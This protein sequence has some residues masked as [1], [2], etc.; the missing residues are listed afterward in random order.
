[1]LNFAI[2]D[3]N[4]N[5]LDRLEKML[6]NIFTK[7]NFDA[8]VSFKANN[9]K[10]MLN[11]VSNNKIDVIMLDIN[12][13]SNKSGLELAEAIR[14]INKNS[15]IIFTTG[16]LEY[17]MIAYKFKT[18]DYLA[19]PITY[20]RLEETIK[21]L[22]DDVN[23]SPKKY[24]KIDNKN[25]IIN[26]AE[27]QYIKRDGMKLVFHT[28]TRDYDTYSSFNK[29]QDRLP[30]T[31]KRCHKSC[32]ANISQIKDVEPVSGII[33]FKD[34]STCD[35]GPK[36]KAD[37]MEVLKLMEILNNL[38]LAVSTPNELLIN[39]IAVPSAILENILILL[40]FMSILNI[41]SN[42]KHK[43][44]FVIIMTLTSFISMN[45]LPN[46]LNISLNYIL[47]IIL[48]HFIF[49]ISF[50]KSFFS[51]VAAALIFNI[52][53][54]LIL[55]PYMTLLDLSSEQLAAIPFY[56]LLYAIIVYS[57]VFI[58]TIIIKKRS[59]KVKFLDDIDRKSKLIIFSNLV[60]GLITLL[61][62]TFIVIYYIDKL[63]ILITF[64]SFISLVAYFILSIYSLTR[65]FKLTL[66]TR[67][68]ESAEEYN[69]TLHILHDNVRGFKHDFDN[70]VTT[71][72][73]YIRTE[74]MEGLK[75]YYLQLEDDCQRVNNLYLLNPEIINND[76]IYNL[77]TK[78][79]NEAEEKD[80]KVN[81]TF[82]L[83]LSTL[84][85]KIYEFAR[86]LGILLDNAIEASSE[87]EERII[88]LT[89]RNDSKNSRELIL[90]ENTYNDKN[91]DTEKIF[92]K[93]VSG[94]DNHTGLGLWEVRKLIKKNNNI[95]LYTSKNDNFFC[96]QLEIYY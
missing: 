56:R 14:K 55:N 66:T 37:L 53:S 31:Y 27:I 8:F 11:Y 41:N 2:C 19:K 47:M 29:F 36:Y 64:L 22:F 69:N 94:K 52:V 30:E 89:F 46:A 60:L 15:Y 74:D 91:L 83:D 32:I 77:L 5:I 67:K 92:E 16:H 85:M 20:D 35:I 44:L 79:Y 13:K 18:F 40:L 58:I 42:F 88:N 21:R 62:Q 45:F 39:I 63:P 84:H 80:I 28:P 33:T 54:A 43:A 72:G 82:L 10:D 17:A 96:Q 78:K 49:K 65:V 7:N 1:M 90:I 24:I 51:I 9:T 57:C 81:I 70:I 12:L 25:T 23:G 50:L 61:V 38:W 73:G 68:L 95:N 71:I 26:E 86:I 87:C 59:L 4:I 34:G 48:T 75:K 3:D 6:E 93:G 76:G